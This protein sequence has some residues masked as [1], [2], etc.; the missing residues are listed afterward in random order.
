MPRYQQ[1]YQVYEDIQGEGFDSL[2]EEIRINSRVAIK[3]QTC[4]INPKEDQH[5]DSTNQD[6]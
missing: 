6:W 4:S 1:E 3:L 5:F 2:E